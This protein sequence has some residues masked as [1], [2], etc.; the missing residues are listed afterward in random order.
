[1]VLAANERTNRFYILAFLWSIVAVLLVKNDFGV[2]AFVTSVLLLIY[3]FGLREKFDNETTASAYSVFNEDSQGITGGFTAAQLEQ[4][5]RGEL[6]KP[7]TDNGQIPVLA[8]PSHKSFPRDIVD[9]TERLRCR[10]AAAAAAERRLK[11]HID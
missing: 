10:E 6:R 1:M 7:N 11:L 4:Q 5:L 3:V 9:T 2:I 8:S